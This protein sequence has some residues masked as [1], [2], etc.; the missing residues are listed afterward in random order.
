MLTKFRVTFR[1]FL[2]SESFAKI[3]DDYVGLTDD[4]ILSVVFGTYRV[5]KYHVNNYVDVS[6][7]GFGKLVYGPSRMWGLVSEF[8]GRF[9]YHSTISVDELYRRVDYCNSILLDL[10]RLMVNVN[11]G[12]WKMKGIGSISLEHFILESWYELNVYYIESFGM[13]FIVPDDYCIHLEN[14]KNRN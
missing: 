9:D 5:Y 7:P 14:F 13:L 10:L 6:I 11:D 4:E 1:K 2:S 8:R 3:S 12:R